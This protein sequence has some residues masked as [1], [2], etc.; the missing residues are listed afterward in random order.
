M[1][2]LSCA[3]YNVHPFMDALGEKMGGLMEKITTFV[4]L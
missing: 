4:N 3:Q 2:I 1:N